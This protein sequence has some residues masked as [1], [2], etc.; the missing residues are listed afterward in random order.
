VIEDQFKLDFLMMILDWPSG[1]L[2]MH[3]MKL[4]VHVP[5]SSS[6]TISDINLEPVVD[7]YHLP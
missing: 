5:K 2:I 1:V 6:P 4:H 7:Y 3:Q